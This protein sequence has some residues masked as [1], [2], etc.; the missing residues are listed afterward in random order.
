[1]HNTFVYGYNNN[2]NN[3]N[4]NTNNNKTKHS[5]V[6]PSIDVPKLTLAARS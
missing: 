1:M 2:N 5:S 4:T 3:N 6:I